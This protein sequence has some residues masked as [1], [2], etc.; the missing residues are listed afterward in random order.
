M[1]GKEQISENALVRLSA[2]DIKLFQDLIRNHSGIYLDETKCN[3][4][5]PVISQHL[6][7]KNFNSFEKYY[8]F[9][10]Q[11]RHYEAEVRGL[12]S[13]VTINETSFFRNPA[14]FTALED[15]V[16]PNIIIER[17]NKIQKLRIW[18]AGCATGEEPYSIAM[19]VMKKLPFPEKWD[20]EIL[21]TDIDY[22]AIKKAEKGIYS[23]RALRNVSK[24]QQEQ[25][26]HQ[27]GNRYELNQNIKKMVDF[28]E[29]NLKQ[30][31][32]PTPE[33]GNWDIIFCRNVIIYFDSEL[34]KQVVRNF[35]R[36][37]D[38]KGHLFLGHSETLLGISDEFSIINFGNTPIY[39]IQSNYANKKISSRKPSERNNMA[40]TNSCLTNDSFVSQT[41][42]KNIDGRNIDTGTMDEQTLVDYYL[43]KGK[44]LAN[45]GSYVSAAEA[46]QKVL[47]ID[48]LCLEAHF[49]MA[50]V[51]ENLNEIDRAVEEYQKTIY[52]DDSCVL[53]H[54]NL[55]R[56]YRL[57]G[58]QQ[59]AVREYRNAV[60]KLQRFPEDE[61]IK[62]SG[63]FSVRLI[64]EICHQK[65]KQLGEDTSQSE[66]ES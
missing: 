7:N 24:G 39:T 62:F 45:A 27:V 60:H 29:F 38:G 50:L 18:S 26:F 53:A 40:L 28:R 13:H 2:T 47:D 32:Y 44:S 6:L 33:K 58:D 43:A 66:V 59:N 12:I 54:F 48:P 36:C 8:R 65:L 42:L 61:E 21:A 9:L 49:F 37:L 56:L 16:L 63:G 31:I 1:A 4:L 19:T 22:N 34:T 23:R 14:Q 10:H 64:N 57:A 55:A 51:S 15:H 25:Y 5:I 41:R 35:G 3:H 46:Y 20:I 30:A 52:V 17:F 11:D